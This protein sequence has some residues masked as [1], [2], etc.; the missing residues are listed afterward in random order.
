MIPLTA[1]WLPIALS[2]VLVFFASAL[3]FL[4]LAGLGAWWWRNGR[5]PA[6][7]AAIP[8]RYEPPEGLSPAEVGT[9]LDESADLDDVT[10]TIDDQFS[11]TSQSLTLSSPF[12]RISTTRK[13]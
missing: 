13:R 1:L 6:G 5:D 3:P 8:V 2:A 10:S 11:R 9:I 12:R 7:A 4:L